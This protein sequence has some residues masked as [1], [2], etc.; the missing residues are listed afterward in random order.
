VAYPHCERGSPIL[1]DGRAARYDDE[2]RHVYE[3]N[4]TGHPALVC[5]LALDHEGLPIGVQMVAARWADEKL[6]AIAR[7][8]APYLRT[9]TPPAAFA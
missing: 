9:F 1:V 3:F 2:C 8:L 5:P 7:S 4:V 6:L